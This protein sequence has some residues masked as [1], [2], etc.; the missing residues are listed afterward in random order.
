V[1]IVYKY[2]E[3]LN[4]GALM[5]AEHVLEFHNSHWNKIAKILGLDESCVMKQWQI[6][7]P[8]CIKE[9][10]WLQEEDKLIREYAQTQGSRNNWKQLSDKL[11]ESTGRYRL[12]KQVRARWHNYLN[13]CIKKEE[14]SREEDT[15]LL[16]YVMQMG[17]RWSQISKL[18]VGRNENTVKNRYNSLLRKVKNVTYNDNED[19]QE[20]KELLEEAKL[21]NLIEQ[22]K[23]TSLQGPEAERRTMD[24]SASVELPT[25]CP[26]QRVK[27]TTS[28]QE[29]ALNRTVLPASENTIAPPKAPQ[30]N[31]SL[32]LS[33][34]LQQVALPLRQSSKR[35]RKSAT[36]FDLE[37]GSA[38]ASASSKLA[39]RRTAPRKQKTIVTAMAATNLMTRFEQSE[40]AQEQLSYSGQQKSLPGD[41]ACQLQQ[42]ANAQTMQNLSQSCAST[43]FGSTTSMTLIDCAGTAP[44]CCSE[45]TIGARSQYNITSYSHIPL[46]Q[47]AHYEA[48]Y[49]ADEIELHLHRPQQQLHHQPEQ[50]KMQNHTSSYHCAQTVAPS[51][52]QPQHQQQQQQQ[53]ES[54]TT[55]LTPNANHYTQ[56]MSEGYHHQQQQPQQQ[57]QQYAVPLAQYQGKQDTQ[58]TMIEFEDFFA[59]HTPAP[60]QQPQPV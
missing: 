12:P 48:P 53:H 54:S 9:L 7:Q 31:L 56:H 1:W 21:R 58:A 2:I 4:N 27:L 34:L 45:R 13:P 20:Q 38:S 10:P 43:V 32:S 57:Q 18:L 3:Q 47:P 29:R 15:A 26:E 36:V 23:E 55:H 42:F 5:T 16:T 19:V 35:I 60:V 44:R 41:D 30:L 52:F 22:L 6:V 24:I 14:W 28:Q 40:D 50:Q 11:F 59:N 8:D 39:A 46:E 25:A 17:K 33:Q 51:H 37:S 49:Y